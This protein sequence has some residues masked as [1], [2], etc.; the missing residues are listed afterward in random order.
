MTAMASDGSAAE[1]PT[2]PVSTA[3]NPLPAEILQSSS[4]SVFR[5]EFWVLG[6][7]ASPAGSAGSISVRVRSPARE[8]Q[9]FDVGWAERWEHIP[10]LVHEW[11]NLA[12]LW[13]RSQLH[14]EEYQRD[15]SGHFIPVNR[16]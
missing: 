14:I 13:V 8:W 7:A 15:E 5:V 12:G 16:M 10:A 4:P 11:E 1:Q 9:R 2:T 3:V 6:S